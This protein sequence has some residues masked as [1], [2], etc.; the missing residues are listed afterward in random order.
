MSLELPDEKLLDPYEYNRA[1]QLAKASAPIITQS[2]SSG[3][4]YGQIQSIISQMEK[5]ASQARKANLSRYDELMDIAEGLISQAGEG[6]ALREATE[7]QLKEAKKQAVGGGIQSAISS[8]LYG[9]TT[10]GGL[11]TAFEKSVGMPT[12]LKLEDILQQRVTEAQKYKA[13]VIER[14]EDVYP[15][16][17]I[18]MSLLSS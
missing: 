8:G 7:M 6:G 10:T 18:L 9:T 4:S 15:D 5:Q 2:S 14:R 1:M 3:V 11:E 12:R 17:G 16:Y 13:G